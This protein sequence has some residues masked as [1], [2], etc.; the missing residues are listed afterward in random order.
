MQKSIIKN[1][2]TQL[3]LFLIGLLF[4]IDC[5]AFLPAGDKST[6]EGFYAGG[7]Y[8]DDAPY[9]LVQVLNQTSGPIP[10]VIYGQGAGAGQNIDGAFTNI[11][12]ALSG[13]ITANSSI[14]FGWCGG[15][16][17]SGPPEPQRFL[18]LSI[19]A[20]TETFTVFSQGTGFDGLGVADPSTFYPSALVKDVSP[21]EG[22][23]SYKIIGNPGGGG[24]TDYNGSNGGY[25][26]SHNHVTCENGCAG[27]VGFIV[28]APP[29]AP[30]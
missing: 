4:T 13:T 22:V 18:Q 11:G 5:S 7:L 29:T 21:S 20:G 3:V 26:W 30:N 16:Y 2:S 19:I 1:I 24:V 15:W 6:C 23:F 27:G 17:Q 9:V 28:N 8:P 12:E 25:W 14:Y 10:Y